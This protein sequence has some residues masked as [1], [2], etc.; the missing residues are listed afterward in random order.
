M[1]IRWGR[2]ASPGDDPD[3]FDGYEDESD[4]DELDDVDGEG[5]DDDD[6]EDDAE[7]EE[8]DLPAST[9]FVATATP[10]EVSVGPLPDD[11]APDGVCLASR[12][13]GRL[14]ARCAMP[15]ES[16]ERLVALKL[17]EEPVL[18]GLLAF[19]GEPGIQGRLVA[20]VP[21]ARLTEG[22]EED[23]PWKASVPSFEEE[24]R[25]ANEEGGGLAAIL[26]GHIVR[27]DRDRKHP[28]DLAQEAVDILQRVVAG[29]PMSDA[30]A[31]AIDD[32]L[33]SL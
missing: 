28:E 17:F 22:S 10:L 15:G 1:T 11:R 31:K 33:D 7:D 8:E 20:L 32:L 4:D 24:Q 30:A 18:V 6:D 14:V 21:A 23:E 19:E 9:V 27:F 5:G 29:A 26:L 13:D 2:G 16:I 25:E 3:D 12:I